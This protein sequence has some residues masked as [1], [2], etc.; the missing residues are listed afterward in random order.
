MRLPVKNLEAG[1]WVGGG[2][3]QRECRHG[4]DR[5]LG[6]LAGGALVR[7]T[8]PLHRGKCLPGLRRTCSRAAG[9]PRQKQHDPVPEAANVA[10]RPARGS[11]SV[12][13]SWPIDASKMSS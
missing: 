9:T 7:E 4:G 6:V 12:S 13:A 11:S 2:E 5:L 3:L 8:Q 1:S 10:A